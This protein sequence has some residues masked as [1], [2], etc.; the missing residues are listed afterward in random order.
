MNQNMIRKEATMITIGIIDKDQESRERLV[1]ILEDATPDPIVGEKPD[2]F[3]NFA[4][5]SFHP[6]SNHPEECHPDIVLIDMEGQSAGS[7]RNIKATYP[8]TQVIVIS[9]SIETAAALKAYRQ[10]AVDYIQ[11]STAGRFLYF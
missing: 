9:D 11:K 1:S 10:G 3:V 4:I 5:E 8:K 7:I 2:L 6:E